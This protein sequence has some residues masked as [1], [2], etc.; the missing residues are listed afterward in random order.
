MNVKGP[1]FTAVI[2]EFTN[3]TYIMVVFSDPNVNLG[4]V[5]YNIKCVKKFFKS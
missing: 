4:A 2:G 5:D 3:N 1:N